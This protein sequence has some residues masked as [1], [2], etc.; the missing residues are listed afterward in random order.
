MKTSTKTKGLSNQAKKTIKTMR[1]LRKRGR[2]GKG[3]YWQAVT[4]R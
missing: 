4:I 3:D 1:D 2:A